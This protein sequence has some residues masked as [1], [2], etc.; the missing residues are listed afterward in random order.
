MKKWF[1]GLI[2]VIFSITGSYASTPHRS[3]AVKLSAAYQQVEAFAKSTAVA[4]FTYNFI[5]Y[6]Q[7]FAAL[8]SHFSPQG[9]R[10]FQHAL[11][12]SGNIEAVVK[13][14]MTVSAAVFG[15]T[16][17]SQLSGEQRWQVIVPINV[18][19]ITPEEIKQQTLFVELVIDRTA[20]TK[21]F[22]SRFIAKTTRPE[23]SAKPTV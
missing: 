4:A 20:K 9:F 3:P 13:Q 8:K 21:Y 14:E 2:C 16:N 7:Q 5:D 1:I 15:K 17:V 22:V 10:A 23:S 18:S 12:A 11:K 19:Y 6:K